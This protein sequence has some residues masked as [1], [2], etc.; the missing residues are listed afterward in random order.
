MGKKV[1]KKGA[2]VSITRKCNLNC[3]YCYQSKL[4]EQPDYDMDDVENYMD[5]ILSIPGFHNMTILGGEA[6]VRKDMVKYMLDRIEKHNKEHK[7][8]PDHFENDMNVGVGFIT[9][10]T[11]YMDFSEWDCVG[12]IQIS[13][14]GYKDLHNETRAYKNGKGSY[15]RIM[16]NYYKWVEDGRAPNIHMVTT[17]DTINRFPDSIRKILEN[18]DIDP[19]TNMGVQIDNRHSWGNPID[20]F[21]LWRFTKRIYNIWIDYDRKINFLSGA[22][23]FAV[24]RAGTTFLGFDFP[25]GNIYGCHENNGHKTYD[26]V[27]SLE[28]RSVDKETIRQRFEDIDSSKFKIH[29]IPKWLSQKLYKKY[30]I[31]I[32]TELNRKMMGDIHVTPFYRFFAFVMFNHYRDKYIDEYGLGVFAK[33]GKQ[34]GCNSVEFDKDGCPVV[35]NAHD[36]K[37]DIKGCH[38]VKYN[39]NGCPIVCHSYDKSKGKSSAKSSPKNERAHT[40]D[41]CDSVRTNYNGCPVVCTAHDKE[42]NRQPKS[43]DDLQGCDNVKINHNGCPVVCTAHDKKGNKQP[44]PDKNIRCDSVKYDHNGCPVVC[45]G[46]DKE[47]KSDRKADECDSV[48]YDYNGC[49]AVCTAHDKKGNKQ[50]EPDKNVRCDNVKYNHNGCPVVCDGHDKKS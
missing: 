37:D 50:S 33:K 17:T 47:D 19:R 30:N 34:R 23:T 35:C 18:E 14:D 48:K 22:D 43:T 31:G 10:G 24:C 49:P 38:E 8:D 15:D 16:E 9:N 12:S 44:E 20:M 36:K 29:G 45:D 46:H 4:K 5:Y 25:S 26:I 28:T 39:E 32:C 11:V 27:G 42:G 40:T 6:L 1:Q 2:Y 7:D 13:L 3:P 21:K 41:A